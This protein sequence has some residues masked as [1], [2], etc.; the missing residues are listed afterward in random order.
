MV[1]M[2]YYEKVS[3]LKAPHSAM[4]S[5]GGHLLSI[6]FTI[7]FFF[8]FYCQLLNDHIN[9]FVTGMFWMN[10]VYFIVTIFLIVY[11]KWWCSYAGYSSGVYKALKI[12]HLDK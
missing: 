12:L 1:G 3:G 7:I 10:I 5:L 2:C 4:I 6:S 8:L 9:F 11:P